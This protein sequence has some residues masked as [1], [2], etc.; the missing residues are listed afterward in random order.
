MPLRNVRQLRTR[1]PRMCWG[2]WECVECTWQLGCVFLIGRKNGGIWVEYGNLLWVCRHEWGKGAVVMEGAGLWASDHVTHRPSICLQPRIALCVLLTLLEL[3]VHSLSTRIA[4][5]QCDLVM[6]FR[7][8]G[9]LSWT[10]K[11]SHSSIILCGICVSVSLH[12]RTHMS[13]FS[14]SAHVLQTTN[15]CMLTLLQWSTRVCSV[16]W[17]NPFSWY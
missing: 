14:L 13:V 7:L 4:H 17:C 5:T 6:A 1:Q 12:I 15:T 3:Y 10:R 16:C 8:L 2:T 9:G 11:V